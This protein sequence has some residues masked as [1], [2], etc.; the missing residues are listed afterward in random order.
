MNDSDILFDTSYDTKFEK[1]ERDGPLKIFPWVGKD[2]SS[3]QKKLLVVGESSY[4]YWEDPSEIHGKNEIRNIVSYWVYQRKDGISFFNRISKLLGVKHDYENRKKFFDK[5]SFYN[6]VQ[7][8][9]DSQYDR[10]TDDDFIDGWKKFIEVISVLQPDYCIFI[11]VS[12]ANYFNYTMEKMGIKHSSVSWANNPIN[13]T[14]PR[15]FT[16]TYEKDN[17]SFELRMVSVRHVSA[18]FNLEKWNEFLK[19]EDYSKPILEFLNKDNDIEVD[20]DYTSIDE[21]HPDDIDGLP[22]WLGHK[23]I[24][25]CKSDENNSDF[26]YLSI[27]RSL[28]NRD[29]LSVKFWRYSES[30]KRWSRQGEEIPL[31]RFLF[32]CGFVISSLLRMSSN[33]LIN[34]NSHFKEQIVQSQDNSKD[35]ELLNKEKMSA[36]IQE[37]VDRIR[38]L[39]SI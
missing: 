17:D 34:R 31:Q 10:P 3:S 13:G 4:K 36:K 20:E 25:A 22:T 23:P 24:I 8:I 33:G 37:L 38:K 19:N 1:I 6:I 29:E 32:A 27:G 16:L 7:K 9:V 14:Y 2:Y 11:G 26:R 15:K 35:I 18:F 28:W 21:I 39:L 5:I 30:G 12:A